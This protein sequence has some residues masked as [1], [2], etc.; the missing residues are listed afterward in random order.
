MPLAALTDAA[1]VRQLLLTPGLVRGATARVAPPRIPTGVPELDALLGGGLAR[2][3]LTEIIG[4]ASSGRTTLACALIGAVTATGAFAA[5]V[6][7]PDAFDAA[8][9]E[10]AGID[11]CRLLWVRPR[12]HRDALQAAEHVLDANGFAL[13]LV[14]VDDAVPAAPGVAEDRRRRMVASRW[15]RLARAALRTRTALVVIAREHVAGTFA[16]L[17]VETAR[18]R[19]AF[20]TRAPCALFTGITTDVHVRKSKL[21]VSTSPTASVVAATGP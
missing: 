14:D 11:L 12:T 5:Y 4:R 19:A 7:L 2:G 9:A 21:A 1:V 8:H 15:L 18:H 20:E 17:R 16:A 13:V 3:A 6:D 10:A